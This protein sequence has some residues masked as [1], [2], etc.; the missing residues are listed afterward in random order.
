MFAINDII[1]KELIS[2]AEDVWDTFWYEKNLQGDIV[3][4]YIWL[5]G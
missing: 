5:I 3:A 4:V 2:Y 1:K